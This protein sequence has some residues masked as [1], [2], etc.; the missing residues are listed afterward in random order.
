MLTGL[1]PCCLKN[2][3]FYWHLRYSTT[4]VADQLPTF[5]KPL[6]I[7][8]SLFCLTNMPYFFHC[9][10]PTFILMMRSM[11]PGMQRASLGK[12]LRCSTM[13]AK[14]IFIQPSNG[15]SMWVGCE[16]VGA[17]GKG[18]GPLQMAIVNSPKIDIL[19]TPDFFHLPR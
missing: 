1:A 9:M 8:F 7:H 19:L 16:G 15:I 18:V 2:V 11:C 3:L 10:A 5:W 17:V 6:A 14:K 4:S 13:K 12:A